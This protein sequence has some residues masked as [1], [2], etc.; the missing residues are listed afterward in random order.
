VA[1]AVGGEV[2][3]GRC[4]DVGLV[5]EEGLREAEEGFGV[6]RLRCAWGRPPVGP[7]GAG[8]GSAKASVRR[9]SMVVRPVV[10]W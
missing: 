1:V 2:G 3:D 6:E 7:G 5:D 4:D 8:G 9:W 10:A